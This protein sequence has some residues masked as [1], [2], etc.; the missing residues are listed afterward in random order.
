MT[1][2]KTSERSQPRAE[3]T[4]RR[5]DLIVPPP[6]AKEAKVS[7]V[8][9]LKPV[10]WLGYCII[11]LLTTICYLPLFQSD[12]VWSEHDQVERSPY[13]SM[14][15]IAE[16]WTL[17]SIRHADP[18]TI[19]SYFLESYS[20][21]PD[22]PTH[23]GINLLLHI[24]A[25]L[26]FLKVLEALKLPAAFSA[27]LVFALH[28]TVLQTIFWAGY[29]NELLGLVLILAAMYF[30]IQN[31]SSR[32]YFMLIGL[33]VLACWIHPAAFLLPFILA[34][35]ILHQ[36]HYPKL[37][38]FNH[39]LP[40]FCLALFIG[41]WSQGSSID[42]ELTLSEEVGRATQNFFFNLG[43]S[44]FPAE[45]ALFY[46]LKASHGFST[47]AQY[48]FLPL[49]LL[50][51]FYVLILFNYKRPWARSVFVGL[52]VYL[53]L[54]LP[55][56]L[57][58]GTFID[59]EPAHEDHLHYVALPFI[60]ALFICALGGVIRILGAG[61]RFIWYS[62]FSLFVLLQI[63]FTLSFA[64][65][66]SDRTS[67]WK[68]LSEQWPD[69]WVPKLALVESV[70]ESDGATSP[71]TQTEMINIMESLVRIQPDLSSIRLALARA[72][73]ADGQSSQ[74]LRNYRWILRQDYPGYEVLLE[75]A[76]FLEAM[77]LSWDARNTRDRL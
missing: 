73:R 53:L 38:D 69:S 4:P 22:A 25:A 8:T 23:H 33:S 18:L 32:D 76:E 13:Q 50:I 44:L 64:S 72:Y 7:K 68:N 3:G 58:S 77:G 26:T 57:R 20:P 37:R 66:I 30:G 21:L 34:L 5:A 74:A 6:R 36:K 49:L 10:G 70:Q 15:T 65:S 28:P 12:L 52:T 54:S 19:S 51:P 35:C 17:Q 62:G 14:D 45:L 11:I 71:L 43:Q 41:L 48:G 59:G 39:L 60:V 63:S 1:S 46:P 56:W 16:A 42:H 75:A 61:G 31:R 40:I 24:A 55:G 27:S 29:R 9:P 67:L 2:D 47:G